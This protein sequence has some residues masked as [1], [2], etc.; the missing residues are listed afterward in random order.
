MSTPERAA[1]NCV[2]KIAERIGRL[3]ADDLE[4]AWARKAVLLARRIAVVVH[5]TAASDHEVRGGNP[6]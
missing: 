1:R 3:A 5:T 2:R 4:P 6:R